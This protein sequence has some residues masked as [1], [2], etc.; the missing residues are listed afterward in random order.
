MPRE[1]IEDK[2][3]QTGRSVRGSAAVS[4][5]DANLFRQRK[6]VAALK[7][8]QR[9]QLASS[10]YADGALRSARVIVDHK[11]YDV[12]PSELAFLRAGRTPQDLGLEP[13]EDQAGD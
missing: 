4:L 1:P 8:R 3:Q 2:G 11:F 9:V 10:T 6:A 7:E 13:V 5:P 12:R